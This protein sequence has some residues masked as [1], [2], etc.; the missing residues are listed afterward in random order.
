MLDWRTESR[1]QA[2]QQV[3]L[4]AYINMY[5]HSVEMDARTLGFRKVSGQL[6]SYKIYA[7]IV[8]A[9]DNQD[10]RPKDKQDLRPKGRLK[11]A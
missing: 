6:T 9:Q 10:R 5:V 4:K 1:L 3:W 11:Y 2:Q 7:V 8:Q